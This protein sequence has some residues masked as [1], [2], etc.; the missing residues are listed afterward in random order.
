MPLGWQ[1]APRPHGPPGG[2][3][4]GVQVV[5]ATCVQPG[6]QGTIGWQLPVAGSQ[7]TPV[8]APQ[9]V[10]VQVVPGAIVPPLFTHRRTSTSV[11]VLPQQ[12]GTMVKLVPHAACA[13]VWEGTNVPPTKLHE[14]CDVV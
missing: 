12:Q 11:Q 10:G 13:Q 4:L 1:H 3:G 9:E 14:P 8:G 7:H 6:G 5:E 2:H